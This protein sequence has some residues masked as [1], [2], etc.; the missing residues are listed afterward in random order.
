MDQL[1]QVRE[2][3]KVQ[4]LDSAG[5]PVTRVVKGQR[6]L[7]DTDEP[8]MVDGDEWHMVGAAVVEDHLVVVELVR[9]GFIRWERHGTQAHWSQ[10]RGD[11][12]LLIQAASLENSDDLRLTDAE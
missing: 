6:G 5:E 12:V 11:G 2:V 4:K 9:G 3:V 1:L 10:I 8:V 7:E